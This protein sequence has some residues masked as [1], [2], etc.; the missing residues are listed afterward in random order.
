ML[1]EVNLEV[2]V[3]LSDRMMIAPQGP[4]SLGAT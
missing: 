3:V 2:G 1:P 4:G